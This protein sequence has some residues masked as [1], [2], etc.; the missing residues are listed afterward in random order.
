MSGPAQLL[1]VLRPGEERDRL[2]ASLE[3]G[4]G[5]VEVVND[6]AAAWRWLEAGGRP[7]VVLVEHCPP[8][9]EGRSLLE[10]LRE[11][12]EGEGV[13]VIMLTGIEPAED[14]RDSNLW[15]ADDYLELPVDPGR[16]RLVVR[17]QVGRAR[18]W[19]QALQRRHR[20]LLS[21][22][23]HELRTPLHGVMGC[24]EIIADNLISPAARDGAEGNQELLGLLRESGERLLAVMDT[25]DFWL[26]VNRPSRRPGRPATP[27]QDWQPAVEQQLRAVVAR[28]Q[29]AAD[30]RLNLAAGTLPVAAV[31]LARVLGLLVDNA[32]KFSVTGQPIEVTGVC[33]GD[34]YALRVLDRGPGL[35]PTQRS[36]IEAF[37][38]FDRSRRQQDGLGLGLATARTWVRQTGGSLQLGARD[39]G[40]TEVVLTWLVAP[41]PAW[42]RLPAEAPVALPETVFA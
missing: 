26:E 31:E 30:L 33:D 4:G 41:A 10:E 28:R 38:Q 3:E 2:Q 13:S 21:F 9:A 35:S 36:Q 42:V 32:A 8:E 14:R 12:P 27:S 1:V 40:G 29:R 6:A 11:R 22:L 17:R 15:P 18:Q 25:V 19:R 34:R 23:P 20:A 16:L 5:V 24:A 37:A 39:G 7:E